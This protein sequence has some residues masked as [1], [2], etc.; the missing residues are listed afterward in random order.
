M[1]FEYSD[2]FENLSVKCP[3]D[4]YLPK[5]MT[6]FRWVFNEIT[7]ERNFKPLALQNP[8]RILDFDDTTK[9]KSFA[10]SVYNSEE[11]AKKRFQFLKNTMGE[12]AY[13]TL[14]TN[15]ASLNITEIDGVNEEPNAQTGHISHHLSK[16]HQYEKRFIIISTL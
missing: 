16:N 9:C 5:N 7:D 14:G 6:V 1:D 12:K 4:D 11:N 10:L 8:K 2:K 3:P 15:I 13:K